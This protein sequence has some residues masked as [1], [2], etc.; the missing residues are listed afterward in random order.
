MRRFV[1]WLTFARQWR[2]MAGIVLS[3]LILST[4]FKQGI[5]SNI[6][7]I[8]AGLLFVIHPVCPEAWKWKY[9]DDD[10][11]MKRNFRIGGAVVIFLGLIT[12]FGV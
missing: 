4:L 11:R 9:G 8:L 12:R 1:N 7:W 2:L 10:S 3:G 6:G 5:F